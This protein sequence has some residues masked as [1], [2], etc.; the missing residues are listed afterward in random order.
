MSNI[1]LNNNCK[2]ELT[3]QSKIASDYQV[4]YIN[5]KN[6]L[7]N[8]ENEIKNIDNLISEQN[9]KIQNK[10]LEKQTNYIG[11]CSP[12]NT[13]ISCSKEC[14][15]VY[16]PNNKD[17]LVIGKLSSCKNTENFNILNKI[18]TT[19][20]NFIETSDKNLAILNKCECSVPN[21]NDI[22]I[23]NEELENL[24]LQK[25]KLVEQYNMANT[26]PQPP[27]LNLK[28]CS[29]KITC[30]DGSCDSLFDDCIIKESFEANLVNNDNFFSSNNIGSFILI[31]ILILFILLQ[32]K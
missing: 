30:K 10:K 5:Y 21:Y 8:I 6:T 29:N 28:C 23:L 9:L 15:S 32:R 20:N 1:N 31:I 18:G 16:N 22:S 3:T 13:N 12:S 17:P 25:T 11:D 26:P 4:N 19:V 14:N 27:I 7:T 2:L 24:N